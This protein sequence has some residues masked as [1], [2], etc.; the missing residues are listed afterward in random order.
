MSALLQAL[1]GRFIGRSK[2]PDKSSKIPCSQGIAQYFVLD[3]GRLARIAA[4]RTRPDH[5]II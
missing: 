1:T 4:G 2:F 3:R 5:G